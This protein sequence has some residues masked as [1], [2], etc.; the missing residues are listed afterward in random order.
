VVKLTYTTM[1]TNQTVDWVRKQHEEWLNLDKGE[2][3][4]LEVIEMLD[5]LIVDG[6]KKNIITMAPPLMGQVFNNLGAGLNL[7]HEAKKYS[8]VPLPLP[9]VVITRCILCAE[10]VFVPFIL[11]TL[12]AGYVSA[13]V[14]TFGGTFLLW[15]LNGV[16]E[17]LCNPFKKDAYTI[18]VADIQEEFNTKLLQILQASDVLTPSLGDD[19]VAEN[20]GPKGEPINRVKQS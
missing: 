17:S 7:F 14:F 2:F 4:I 15:F 10:C 8:E 19:F 11:A 12:T 9:Y 18:E 16:A 1:H 13:C 3:T 6:M 5:N 20:T